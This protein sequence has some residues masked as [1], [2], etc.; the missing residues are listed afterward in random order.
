MAWCLEACRSSLV[1]WQ[2]SFEAHLEKE[3]DR[4]LECMRESHTKTLIVE[5]IREYGT[6]FGMQGQALEKYQAIDL[7]DLSSKIE[8]SFKKKL[9]FFEKNKRGEALNPLLFGFSFV[10]FTTAI[11]S[12]GVLPFYLSMPLFLTAITVSY[13]VVK[14][15][16]P[17][18]QVLTEENVL[19]ATT[20]IPTKEWLA[21]AMKD[22]DTDDYLKEI[23]SLVNTGRFDLGV[24]KAVN[25]YSTETKTFNF[26][27]LAFIVFREKFRQN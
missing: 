14:R 23:D 21:I 26:L 11:L 7:I 9:L 5:R 1:G 13:F 3:G 24:Q 10:F 4:D 8:S 15:F 6:R 2:S 22:G 16:Q 17:S 25:K 19:L 12:V 27:S 20:L 18:V